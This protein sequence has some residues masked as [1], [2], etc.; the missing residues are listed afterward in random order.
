MIELVSTTS[1]TVLAGKAVPLTTVALHTGCAE[2]HRPSSS[3]VSLVKP[4]IYLITANLDIAIPTGGTVEAI[5]A[6]LAVEGE[7]LPGSIMTSTPAAVENFSNVS[8]SHLVKVCFPCCV[9][10]SIINNSTQSI[11]MQ[12]VNLTAER[13][14]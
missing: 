14:A 7:A 1:Q 13:K 12:N 3:V 9:E 8:T 2:R 6:A 4:G 10:V 5:T 11:L